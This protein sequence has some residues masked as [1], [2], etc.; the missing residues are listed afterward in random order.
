[1]VAV[2]R[3]G[4]RL[5]ST[6]S[7]SS[8]TAPKHNPIFGITTRKSGTK[9]FLNVEPPKCYYLRSSGAVSVSVVRTAVGSA[10]ALSFGSIGNIPSGRFYSD[11]PQGV[12]L[13]S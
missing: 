12:W 9:I 4:V 1:M 3:G 10:Q 11:L 13:G 5:S 6:A 2:K 7:I 8:L